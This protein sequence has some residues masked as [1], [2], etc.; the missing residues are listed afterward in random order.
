M[1]IIQN[2]VLKISNIE[3]PE[4]FK[5]FLEE[6][7]EA[8]VDFIDDDI[9]NSTEIEVDE[10]YEVFDDMMET[11]KQMVKNFPKIKFTVNGEEETTYDG[12]RYEIEYNDGTMTIKSSERYYKRYPE[13][14]N[15][16]VDFCE[17]MHI[18]NEIE[19]EEWEALNEDID[20]DWYFI[21][22]VEAK[23]SIKLSNKQVIK[24]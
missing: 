8:F 5:E 23:T 14:Y 1:E 17:D 6:E 21:E 2:A 7:G 24:L 15:E 20:G 19:E 13:N 12:F 22:G 16:F 18:K 10:M 4:S 3:D 11:L 9:E